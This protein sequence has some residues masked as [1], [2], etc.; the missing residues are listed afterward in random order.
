MARAG[1]YWRRGADV[2]PG[3][4]T[5]DAGSVSFAT[6]DGLVFHAPVGDVSA[7]FSRFGTLTVTAGDR[8]LDLVAGAYAGAFARPFSPAQLELLAGAEH[9][10]QA[11]EA[12]RGGATIIVSSSVA[13]SLSSLAGSVAGAALAS[14]GDAVGVVTLFRSQAQS[15]A[16]ARAWAQHIAENGVAVRMTGTTFARSQ[17]F[18]AAIILPAIAVFGGGVA[19]VVLAL[20]RA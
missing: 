4:M 3:V 9:A 15:F 8:T 10:S 19:A 2:T 6:D 20:S 11:R 18:L 5:V 12:F 17:A 13:R 1:L 16:F 7:V 14:A